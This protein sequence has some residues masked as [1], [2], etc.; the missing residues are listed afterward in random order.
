MDELEVAKN[1]LVEAK[2]SNILPIAV[3][4]TIVACIIIGLILY[5]L[6][7]KGIIGKKVEKDKLL[8]LSQMTMQNKNP[9]MQ[10]NVSNSPPNIPIPKPHANLSLSGRTSQKEALYE[11]TVLV[12]DSPQDAKYVMGVSGKMA[13]AYLIRTSMTETIMI[14]SPEFLI[15]KDHTRVHYCIENNSAISRCHAKIEKR[16]TTYYLSDLNSTN[17]TYLNGKILRACE[18]VE[19]QNGDII[20]FSNEEFSFHQA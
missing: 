4:S 6:K 1:Q 8:T 5:I 7:L 15:G 17:H 20:H 10:Q 13:N 9:A 14:D 18:E 2:E 12:D 3:I 16:G 19:L 11:T